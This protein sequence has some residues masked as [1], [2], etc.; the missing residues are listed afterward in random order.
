MIKTFCTL[1]INIINHSWAY[2]KPDKQNES[3][4]VFWNFIFGFQLFW[5]TFWLGAIDVNASHSRLSSVP[6]SADEAAFLKNV[7]PC[8]WDFRPGYQHLFCRFWCWCLL[9]L[10]QRCC[11]HASND[12]DGT[13]AAWLPLP[14]LT[15][16]HPNISE[17]LKCWG[18]GRN[19]INLSNW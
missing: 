3:V 13:A 14:C 9:D 2:R 18:G 19:L 5:I 16:R 4:K 8:P 10:P 1:N 12:S 6:K 17:K 15:L 7:S 11:A